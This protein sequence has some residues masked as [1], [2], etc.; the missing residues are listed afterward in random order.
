MMPKHAGGA[1]STKRY[2]KRLP[3]DAVLARAVGGLRSSRE[4]PDSAC[5]CSIGGL[6]R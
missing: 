5:K 2:G 6:R 4:G 3:P 1:G